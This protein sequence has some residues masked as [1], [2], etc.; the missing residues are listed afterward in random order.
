MACFGISPHA[1]MYTHAVKSFVKV[2]KEFPKYSE[3]PYSGDK[4]F[5]I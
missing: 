5:S 1:I 2:G 4:F 3:F